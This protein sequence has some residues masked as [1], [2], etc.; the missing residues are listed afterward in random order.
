MANDTEFGLACMGG[1]ARGCHQSAQLRCGNRPPGF[2][3]GRLG[4]SD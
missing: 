2:L 4:S 3:T 1:I